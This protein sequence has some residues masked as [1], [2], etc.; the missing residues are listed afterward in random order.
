MYT[1]SVDAQEER[2][3]WLACADAFVDAQL[4]FISSEPF[5]PPVPYEAGVNPL[6]ALLKNLSSLDDHALVKYVAER[7]P[8]WQGAVLTKLLHDRLIADFHVDLT[9]DVVT[10]LV[11]PL[12]AARVVQLARPGINRVMH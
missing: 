12:T 7:Q 6:S 8:F 9:S 4:K 3:G 11:Q 1:V 2:L 5:V 10:F